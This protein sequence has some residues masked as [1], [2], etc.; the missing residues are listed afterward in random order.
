MYKS[1]NIPIIRFLDPSGFLKLHLR[2]PHKWYDRKFVGYDAYI[3]LST[4]VMLKTLIKHVRLKTDVL[5]M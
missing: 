4:R 5:V 2:V 3:D 1:T